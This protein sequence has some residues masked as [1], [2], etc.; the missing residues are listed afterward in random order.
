MSIVE[1]LK[2]NSVFCGY[3]ITVSC[4]YIEDV[5][6]QKTTRSIDFDVYKKKR[7]FIYFMKS[8]LFTNYSLEDDIRSYYVSIL[9]SICMNWMFIK[10]EGW[11]NL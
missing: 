9:P 1:H 10:K 7:E 5:K 11:L 6:K 3:V 4:I 8:I 2:V